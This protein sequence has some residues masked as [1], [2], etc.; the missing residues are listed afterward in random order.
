[1]LAA[2]GGRHT[3]A[4]PPGATNAA[5]EKVLNV[6]NWSDYIAP[7]VIPAFEKEY[8]IK[9]HYDVFE[10]NDVLE[11]KLLTGGSGYDI[12]VPTG[13]YLARAI[14]SG[15]LRELD[16]SAISNFGNIDPEIA[17]Q[18]ELLDPGRRYAAN[19]LISTMGIGYDAAKISAALPGAPVDSLRM[20]FDP[21]RDPALREVRHHLRRRAG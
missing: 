11:T 12:V 19:Y 3:G 10:S 7:D 9:V 16:K 5:E 13:P 1:M 21:K 4:A 15:V 2:C 8:G 18:T 20:V 14:R 6:Y 17:R